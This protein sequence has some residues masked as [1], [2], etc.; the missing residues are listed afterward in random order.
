MLPTAPSHDRDGQLPTIRQFKPADQEAAR[1]LI[2][3]GLVEHWGTLDP[4][5][6]SDLRNIQHSYP[7]QGHT[8]L[9]ALHGGRI[10][11]T[12]ALL[13]ETKRRGRITRMSVDVTLRL[14]L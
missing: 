9:V 13:V 10:V 12:G 6:N 8:F 2:L 3:A 14:T 5:K 4:R 1:Q 7:D 11:G